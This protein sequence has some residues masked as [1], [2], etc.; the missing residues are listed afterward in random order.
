[1]VAGGRPTHADAARRSRLRDHLTNANVLNPGDRAG[2]YDLV[3][4]AES[5]AAFGAATLDP[6]P[7]YFDGT[8]LPPTVIATQAYRAQFA[9]LF[10]L[11][12]ESV[13]A[14]ARGGVHGQHELLLHRPIVPDETLQTIIETHSVRSSGE[15][16]RITLLH[17]TYDAEE[18]LVAEQWW[19]T[20]ML[21]TTA[22]PMGPALPDHAVADFGGQH[23]ISEE[24]VRI[25][26]D[27]ARRYGQVS[28]DFSEH[29]FDVEAARRSG[30]EG[31]F[32]HGLC[33]MALCAR[34]VIRTVCDGDP[35][36]LQRLAVRFASPA[37]LDRDLAVRIFALG[38]DRYALEAMCGE[39]TVV[40][41]GL[42]EL[43]ASAAL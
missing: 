30:Y 10:Q 31:P 39:D 40:R 27:M 21:G 24:I 25:D 9:A 23:P 3:I 35:T 20:V 14:E 29:H 4:D 17:K 6:N 2:P 33:T 13:F 42:A 19:T 22:E 28:G 12:P 37:L 32:L 41:N 38:G 34:A 26:L 18:H 15:N 43:R 5:A 36:R 1:M 8:A 7:R 16:L 11:V